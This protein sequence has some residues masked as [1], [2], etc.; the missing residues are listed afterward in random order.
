MPESQ[1]PDPLTDRVADVVDA[2]LRLGA[3]LARTLASA[4]GSKDV[5]PSGTPPLDD[6]VSF[7]T[8]TASNLIGLV[9]SGVRAG[10][11]VTNRVA[12]A[13]GVGRPDQA[14][15]PSSS[16]FITVGSTLRMPLLV[17]NTGQTPTRSLTFSTTSIVRS[18]CGDGKACTCL[19]VDAVRFDPE[20]LIVAAR[21]FEKLTVRITAPADTPPGDYRASITAGDGWFSTDIGFSVV[22]AG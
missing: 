8:A 19:S 12:G 5:A 14:P 18:G 20:T 4:T 11:D 10:I 3:S 1:A 13:A 7:G 9:A 15:A 2:G 6:V 22:E 17:E 21:D 16:P